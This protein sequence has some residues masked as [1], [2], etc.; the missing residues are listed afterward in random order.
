MN[1]AWQTI[2]RWSGAGPGSAAAPTGFETT[3]Q[4]T[5]QAPVAVLWVFLLAAAIVIW[6]VY[7]REGA[8]ARGWKM[9]LAA[10]RT[11]LLALTVLLLYGWMAQRHRTERPDLI[12]MLDDS[13]SMG[14]VDTLDGAAS[15]A[16]TQRRLSRLALKE[17]TRLNLAK[18]LLLENDAALLRELQ[19]HYK[20]RGYLAGETVRAWPADEQEGLKSLG[21]ISATQ[22]AS[23]LGDSLRDVL[24]AQRGKVTPAVIVLTDGIT[25]DGQSLPAAAEMARR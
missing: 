21:A 4:P 17:P 2:L 14:I 6:W 16:Q 25:T 5:W 8:P 13:A 22:M 18:A 3:I 1:Q 23:R 7:W 19:R 10:I 11:S 24:A 12:L 9:L 20:V 15:T